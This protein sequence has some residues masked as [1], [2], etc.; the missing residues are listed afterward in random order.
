MSLTRQALPLFQPLFSFSRINSARPQ[1]GAPHLAWN[2]KPKQFPSALNSL[3]FS[4][5]FLPTPVH[6][7][8]I[9]LHASYTT[10]ELVIRFC[11]C[12]H[13]CTELILYS[14]IDS[15]DSA[16]TTTRGDAAGSSEGRRRVGEV[17]GERERE[18]EREREAEQH[19]GEWGDEGANVINYPSNDSDWWAAGQVQ[20]GWNSMEATTTAAAGRWL[21]ASAFAPYSRPLPP[22]L[23]LHEQARIRSPAKSQAN[24]LLSLPVAL[25]GTTVAYK[26]PGEFVESVISRRV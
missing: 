5:F 10:T 17:G 11:A 24:L 16:D 23:F 21:R 2:A 22:A 8:C 4:S 18:R 13:R 25:A 26:N 9:Q 1:Q 20:P 12:T 7:M 15:L 6:Y 19:A 14:S 3:S